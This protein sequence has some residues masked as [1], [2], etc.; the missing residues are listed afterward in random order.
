MVKTAKD[1]NQFFDLTSGRIT[2]SLILLDDGKLVSCALTAKTIA[3]RIHSVREDENNEGSTDN[4]D[5][6]PIG[7]VADSH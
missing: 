4:E 1:S 5:H 6:F 3:Q 2:K 7:E